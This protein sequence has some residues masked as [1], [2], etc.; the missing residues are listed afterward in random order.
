MEGGGEESINFNFSF[1]KKNS[2]VLGKK[3]IISRDEFFC[4]DCVNIPQIL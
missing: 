3:V 2:N 1:E 4:E